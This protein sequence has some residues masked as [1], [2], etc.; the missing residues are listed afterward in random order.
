MHLAPGRVP[1][2]PTIV[3]G[4]NAHGQSVEHASRTS[5]GLKWSKTIMNCWAYPRMH[6]VRSPLPLHF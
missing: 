6:P 5:K 3:Q 1:F 2:R 4:D